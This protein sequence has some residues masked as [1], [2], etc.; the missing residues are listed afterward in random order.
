MICSVT[1]L[2]RNNMKRFFMAMSLCVSMLASAAETVVV[3]S[4]YAANHVGHAALYKIFEQANKNQ[5][6]YTFILELKPGDQGVVAL[7]N[8]DQ[9]P[10][11][12]LTLIAAPFVENALRGK[13]NESD[14]VAV[15]SIGH[16]C[17]F[18]TSTQ[19]DEQKGLASLAAY[20]GEIVGGAPGIGS[21]A[22]L[23]MLEIAEKIKKPIRYIS[24]KS[25]AEAN[26]LIAGNNQVNLGNMAYNE[27]QNLKTVNPNLKPLAI[28]CTHRNPALP[29]VATTR[30][31]GINSPY[32]FNTIVASKNMS[33]AKRQE[34]EFVLNQAIL[35]VGQEQILKI[36]DFLPPIFYRQSVQQFHAENVARLK[37]SLAKHKSA[38]EAASK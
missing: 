37:Q 4:P 6:K 36:S 10:D 35:N 23:T 18:L 13:I 14:Y 17:W 12:A 21:A 31:Q 34:L 27:L 33:D 11:T 3:K 26:V 8:M 38:V 32:V 20:N 22:H 15:S 16:A 2:W 5:S 24:F 28:H 25:A 29:H 19:G 9:T 1:L 7:K 30:E